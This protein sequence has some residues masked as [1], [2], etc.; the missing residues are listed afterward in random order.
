MSAVGVEKFTTHPQSVSLPYAEVIAAALI[1]SPQTFLRV[2]DEQHVTWSGPPRRLW[3][4]TYAVEPSR[5][6]LPACE[7][8]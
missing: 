7:S 1:A 5:G 6:R 8:P 2:G 3:V 4:R